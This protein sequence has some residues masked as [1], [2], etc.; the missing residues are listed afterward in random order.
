M[1]ELRGSGLRK[2]I[3]LPHGDGFSPAHLVAQLPGRCLE[4]AFGRFHCH[5]SIRCDSSQGTHRVHSTFRNSK[6]E[7]PIRNLKI[8][9]TTTRSAS[10]DTAVPWTRDGEFKPRGSCVLPSLGSPGPPFWNKSEFIYPISSFS[11]L[12]IRTG[13]PALLLSINLFLRTQARG[14][15]L[16]PVLPPRAAA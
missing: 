1:R 7:F 5:C 12:V 8:G 16:Q 13:E 10:A 4:A 15:V 11:T 14:H 9:Q 6:G 3:C 2:V